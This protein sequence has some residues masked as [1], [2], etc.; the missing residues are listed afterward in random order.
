[1]DILSLSLVDL[2][3]AVRAG[4]LSSDEV[5]RFYA[6]RI[7]R[8]DPQLNA[9]ITTNEPTET[10]SV[11]TPLAGIP[12]GVKDIFCENGIRTAAASHMLENFIPPYDATLITRLK[13]AG[14]RSI[15]K[16]NMDEFSMG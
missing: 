15:G 12:L 14:F 9:F 2:V 11:D 13:Q 5:Y 3:A 10:P 7:A 6:E 4:T 8:L 1:M 16:C